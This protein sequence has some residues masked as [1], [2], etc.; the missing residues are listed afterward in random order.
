[1]NRLWILAHQDDEIFGLHLIDNSTNNFVLYLTDGVR[2]GAE[3][4]SETRNEEARKSWNLLDNRA[5]INFFGSTR[6]IK[7][8]MLLDL[9][10]PSHLH[11]IMN[12]CL[13]Q[14]INEVI[15]LEFEGGHQD[16]DIAS[17]I[18][19]EISRRL[20]LDCLTYTSYR[21][22]HKSF[23]FYK[24]MSSHKQILS[25]SRNPLILKCKLTFNSFKVMCIYKTQI[26][27]WFGLG[28]FIVLRYFLGTPGFRRVL[29]ADDKLDLLPLHF[30]YITRRKFRRID[31]LSFL[32]KMHNW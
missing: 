25:E 6:S 27:T 16:H 17:L 28:I 14:N 8:G 7:D 15:T 13:L 26:S 23:P 32:H 21:S 12:L 1:M 24:V 4:S 18:S 9:F 10:K 30:L 31:F 29:P 19:Q 3:Y 5:E 2:L 11:E 20:S 22:I